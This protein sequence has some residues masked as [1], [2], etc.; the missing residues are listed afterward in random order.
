LQSPKSASSFN[1]IAQF[2]QVPTDKQYNLDSGITDHSDLVDP[3]AGTALSP[4]VSYDRTTGQVSIVY[5][6]AAVWGTWTYA[7][8]WG[9]SVRL[10]G[11]TAL[12][13]TAAV[14]GAGTTGGFSPVEGTA[15][16]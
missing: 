5:D 11:T 3:A 16:V 9:T 10:N 8:V 12:W 14:W 6:A 1:V 2:N 7:A 15:A 13:G 4:T